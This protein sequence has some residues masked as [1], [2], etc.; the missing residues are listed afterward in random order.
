MSKFYAN[1]DKPEGEVM[2]SK[3]GRDFILTI[4]GFSVFKIVSP[5][6]S[7]WGQVWEI[8]E[9]DQ[10]NKRGEQ[11][12]K[13]GWRWNLKHTEKSAT[14]LVSIKPLITPFSAVRAKESNIQFA[15]SFVSKG[16]SS[17]E[18]EWLT[19]VVREIFEEQT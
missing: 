3:E 10:Y 8:S 9:R 15:Y 4:K 16:D 19:L 12:F 2:C 14:H 7:P 17:R 5:V 1:L 18:N 11:N 6:V 13:N